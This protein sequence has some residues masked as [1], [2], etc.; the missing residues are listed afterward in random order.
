LGELLF[1][2]GLVAAVIA[3]LA[4]AAWIRRTPMVGRGEMSGAPAPERRAPIAPTSDPGELSVR[5]SSDG[6]VEPA[7]KVRTTVRSVVV[8]RLAVTGQPAKETITVDGV[9]YGSVDE[10][11][12]PKLRDQIR[13]VLHD[14]P[15]QID[16]PDVREK[17]ERDLADVGIEGGPARRETPPNG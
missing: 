5:L 7:T 2:F 14:V 13:S 17:A 6:L 10:I 4:W 11:Q 3:I 9:Q 8:R 1:I 12:D 15:A 16:D